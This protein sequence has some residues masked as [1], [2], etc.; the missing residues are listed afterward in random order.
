MSSIAEL[1]DVTEALALLA[2]VDWVEVPGDVIG[3]ALQRFSALRSTLDAVEAAATGA[4]D[5]SK[6]W[7]SDGS[8][9]PSAWLAHRT[10][11]PKADHDRHRHRARDL[12]HMPVVAEA[13]RTGSISD[14]HVDALG[15]AQASRPDHFA[16]AEAFLVDKAR[17]LRWRSFRQAVAHWVH[18]VD[19][20]ATD[21]EL[22]DNA[23]RRQ[24]HA[25]KTING[26]GRLDAWL[27][28]IA[29]EAFNTA[30]QRI[31]GELFAT[32]WA[33]TR[34][35]HGPEATV[36]DLART[37]A[38]RRADA[39]VEMAHRAVTAPKDGLR[40]LPLVTVVC[41]WATFEHQLALL[42]G[43][44]QPPPID[45]QC[46]LLDGTP[47]APA[48][49]FHQALLGHVR[50]MV[51]GRDGVTIDMG[52]KQRFFTGAVRDAVLVRYQ[53]CAHP[54]CEVPATRCEVDHITDWA[55]GGRTDQSNGQPLCDHHNRWKPRR[56]GP[57]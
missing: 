52:R 50:R 18:V 26:M 20:A 2:K 9:S 27:D 29:F 48:D 55:H 1:D 39:L 24:L 43:I 56:A 42:T 38:Q 11:R 21:R 31:E 57:W 54:T 16:D 41:D 12:Q 4:F 32:D 53:T 14:R 49:M 47:I 19:P 46:R 35:E 15:W 10:R 45:G 28:P 40:P 44:D 6:A 23:H 37:P 25:S 33:R 22:H 5:R 8:K 36:A 51:F 34:A 13:L 17:N 30:L 3:G 7:T